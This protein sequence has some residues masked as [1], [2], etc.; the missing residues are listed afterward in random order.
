M[1][2]RSAGALLAFLCGAVVAAWPIELAAQETSLEAQ[3]D[4]IFAPWNG[5]ESPGCAVSVMRDG[6]I[7]YTVGGRALIEQAHTR[8]VLERWPADVLCPRLVHGEYRGLRTVGHGGAD[9]GYR[10]NFVR[11]SDQRLSMAVLCN[12]P[13]SNPGEKAFQ[14]ADVYLADT[15]ADRIDEP[16][17]EGVD[18]SNPEMDRIVGVYRQPSSDLVQVINRR[19]GTLVVGSSPSAERTLIPL[20]DNHFRRAGSTRVETI[21]FEGRGGAPRLRIPSDTGEVVYDWA[22]LID[23]SAD[24]LAAYVGQYYSEEVVTDYTVRVDDGTLIL[25]HRKRDDVTLQ[26][27]FA[28][29]FVAP[30]QGLGLTFTRDAGDRVDGLTLSSGRVRKVRFERVDVER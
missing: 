19:E 8:G 7:V 30:N 20:G 1:Q 16:D 10:S 21:D 22:A 13:T 6:A 29:G 26:P 11:F 5:P 24:E 27:T 9:A 15:L 18:L 17:P 28:D 25:A 14:V 2:S 12:F 23:P 3:V 4:E